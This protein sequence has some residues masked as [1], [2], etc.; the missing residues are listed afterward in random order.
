VCA[1]DLL[2]VSLNFSEALRQAPQLT[3]F[4]G[5]RRRG[6]SGGGGGG[7]GDTDLGGCTVTGNQSLFTV[8]AAYVR[9][10]LSSV[11]SIAMMDHGR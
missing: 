6:C 8:T 3:V 4:S 5:A 11:T 1:G 10:T 2:F 7:G 9:G